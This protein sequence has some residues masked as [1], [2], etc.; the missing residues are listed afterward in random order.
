MEGSF[1]GD[2]PAAAQGPPTGRS[3]A[4][5]VFPRGRRTTLVRRSRLSGDDEV[6]QA[7]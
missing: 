7:A 5:P 1:R 6:A 2:E 3:L 4:L